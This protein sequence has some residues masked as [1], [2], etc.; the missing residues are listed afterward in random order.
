MKYIKQFE[1]P[2]KT[3]A[4]RILEDATVEDC[5][6]EKVKTVLL[7]TDP[8]ALRTLFYKKVKEFQKLQ[9]LIGKPK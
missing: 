9:Y 4:Q 1:V 6:K 8:I 3:P 2:P 5:Y 7:S